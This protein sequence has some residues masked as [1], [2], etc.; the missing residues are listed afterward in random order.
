VKLL[1]T[2]GYHVAQ[3]HLVDMFPQTYHIE[4]AFVLE[5]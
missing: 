3:A 1:L 4:S 5:R 2:A